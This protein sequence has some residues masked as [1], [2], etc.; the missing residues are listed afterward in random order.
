MKSYGVGIKDQNLKWVVF[1]YFPFFSHWARGAERG[2]K[3]M[4]HAQTV[5]MYMHI[6]H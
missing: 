3:C 2:E 4:W 5:Y 6:S 1:S